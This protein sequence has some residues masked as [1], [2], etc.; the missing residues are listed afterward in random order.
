MRL[1]V[2]ESSVSSEVPMEVVVQNRGAKRFLC[3]ETGYFLNCTATLTGK[4]GAAV[5]RTNLGKHIFTSSA[6]GGGQFALVTLSSGE[7]RSW[8]FNLAEAFEPMPKGEYVLNLTARVVVESSKVNPGVPESER[9]TDPI[10]LVV[11]NVPVV[12]SA[13]K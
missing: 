8:T 3:G 7:A 9:F 12:I 4:H 6:G 10:D 13:K 1:L 11:K 2:P 5:S